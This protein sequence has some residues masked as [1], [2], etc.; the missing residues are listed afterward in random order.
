MNEINAKQSEALITMVSL[1]P[2]EQREW[3]TAEHLGSHS[4]TLRSLESKGLVESRLGNSSLR[5]GERFG[6]RLT[7]RGYTVAKK[8]KREAA[9]S[10]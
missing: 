4:A 9:V 3:R 10:A 2:R 5:G 8:A 6:Y 7:N 1:S